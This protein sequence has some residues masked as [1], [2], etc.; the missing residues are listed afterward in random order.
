[1]LDAIDKAPLKVFI[2]THGC[3]P[4]AGNVATD[5]AFATAVFCTIFAILTAFSTIKPA[6]AIALFLPAKTCKLLP[7]FPILSKPACLIS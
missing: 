3:P 5:L 6:F 2:P 1:M 4:V 7:I